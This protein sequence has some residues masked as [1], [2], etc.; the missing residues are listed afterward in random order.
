MDN[1]FL[2]QASGATGAWVSLG[3][4]CGNGIIEAIRGHWDA[5]W[6]LGIQL[7]AHRQHWVPFG[8]VGAPGGVPGACLVLMGYHRNA[9][10][11]PLLRYWAPG[12]GW[13]E[14]PEGR[15]HHGRVPGGNVGGRA[16]PSRDRSLAAFLVVIALRIVSIQAIGC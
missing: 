2:D 14:G 10:D 13:G 11:R 7:G 12:E 3:A 8:G 9:S 6:A 16:C 5:M 15:H 1:V 4:L